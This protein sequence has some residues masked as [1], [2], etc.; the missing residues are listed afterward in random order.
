MMRFWNKKRLTLGGQRGFTL[1]EL[2][3]V[4]AI[5]GI[6]A[7]IAIPVFAGV[8]LSARLAK[9]SADVRT[10]G[11]A[12]TIYASYCGDIPAAAAG[13]GLCPVSAGAQGAGAPPPALT[14]VQQAPGVPVPQPSGPF[15]ANIP[16]PP[17]GGA[18]AWP[19]AYGYN[20]NTITGGALAVGNFVVCAVG[21]GFT[22]STALNG[23]TAGG[24]CP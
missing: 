11:S 23:P 5:I 22:V 4:V 7:A 6:L 19:A 15:L 21:D 3:I 1:I 2:M 14:L 12:L 13:G 20:P 9:A 8:Q 16:L 18:P 24:A 10:I 17:A